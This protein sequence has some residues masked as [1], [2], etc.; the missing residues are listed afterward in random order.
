MKY[1]IV[2]AFLVAS[3]ASYA[4]LKESHMGAFYSQPLGAFAST[5][6]ADDGGYAEAGW[7]VVFDSWTLVEGWNDWGYMFHSTYQWNDINTEQL[8]SDYTEALG[9]T[10]KSSE[11]RYSPLLTTIGPAYEIGLGDKW[12]LGLGAT[13]GVLFNNTRDITLDTYDAQGAHLNALHVTFDNNVAFAYH[14][15]VNLKFTLV[16]DL[17][18]LSLFGEYTGATQSTELRVNGRGTDSSQRIDYLNFGLK[19]VVV[20]D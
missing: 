1:L 5:D 14:A 16:Q 2:A 7:G 9:V 10:V 11:S 3:M 18:K 6:Y 19:L 8:A 4:Q 15:Q 12:A 13:A 20:T 17:M